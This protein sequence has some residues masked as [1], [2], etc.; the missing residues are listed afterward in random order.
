MVRL[1]ILL[2]TLHGHSCAW[3]D[4]MLLPVTP[5]A[6]TMDAMQQAELWAAKNPELIGDRRIA[7]TRC[8]PADAMRT[9]A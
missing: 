8:V 3:H 5:I 4:P 6:C 2:C 1:L 9:P 7:G